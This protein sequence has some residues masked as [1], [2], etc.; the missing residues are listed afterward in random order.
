MGK[1]KVA[2]NGF[3]RIGRSAFKIAFDRPDLE[4]VAIN[5]LTD[6]KTLAHLLKYDSNYGTYSHDVSADESGI[7]VDGK[8]IQV[9]A[10]KDPSLLPWTNLGIDVV[11][12]CTGRFTKK[13]DA[14]LHIKAG[15]KRVVLS[16]PTKSEGIDTIVYGANEEKLKTATPVISNASCTTNS[17]GAVMAILDEAI[18]IEKALLTTVHSYTASQV[19]QDAPSK[20]L[21][22]GRNAAE[23]IVPTTTGAAVAVALTLPQLKGKFD[24]MSVRVPTPVVSL[25]DVTILFK[26]DTSVDEINAILKK[27]ANE[28]FYQG[29]L[30]VSDVPLVSS[31]YIGNSHSGIVDLLL[32]NVVGGN[33]AKVVVWY[34]NEW[35]YS[36]RLVEEVADVGKLLQ[37]GG[38]LGLPKTPQLPE[39]DQATRTDFS[40]VDVAT[41]M[42][43]SDKINS[44]PP[45][46]HSDEQAIS[47]KPSSGLAQ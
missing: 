47:G 16:S 18:G 14:E 38:G 20:D 25:S 24:G 10:E 3:G 5:D 22:E 28:P 41:A 23:N 42:P 2:I 34:D 8:K 40:S 26:K 33:L 6:N 35:G 13:E 7:T 4:I 1:T 27:A 37:E 30:A 45:G 29:I 31:D 44:E 19:L 46:S 21:R 39:S 12:E 9:L 36:N 15:A 43:S 32:T 17:L 11:I